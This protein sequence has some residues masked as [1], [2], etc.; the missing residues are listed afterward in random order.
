M[1]VFEIDDTNIVLDS[2]DL[3]L[4]L[5][6]NFRTTFIDFGEIVLNIKNPKIL[7]ITQSIFNN[8]NYYTVKIKDMG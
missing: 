6:R 3:S 5:I 1:V 4:F 8:K 2:L 7:D